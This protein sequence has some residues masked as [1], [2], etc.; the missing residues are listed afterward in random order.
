VI[1]TL[2]VTHLDAAGVRASLDQ[3]PPLARVVVCHGGRRED[4]EAVEHAPKLF[5]ADPSLRGPVERQ[6]YAALLRQAWREAVDPDADLVYLVEYDHIVLRPD[7]ETALRQ[8]IEH[9]GADFLGKNCSRRDDT[10]WTHSLR[11]R[12]DP[13]MRRYRELWGCL[14]TGMLFRR[15]ALAAV[16]E[17]REVPGYLE[18]AIPTLLR[19]EGLRLDDVDRFSDLYA[20]VNA[21]PEKDLAALRAARSQGHFFCHPFKRVEQLGQLRATP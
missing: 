5:V 8:V 2:L 1:V 19:A 9:S 15:E 3:F 11:A 20:H 16:G 18:L 6:S 7:F 10:N 17:A 21:P 12:R 4:F 14:G 13:R